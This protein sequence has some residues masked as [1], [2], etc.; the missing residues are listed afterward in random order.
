MDTHFY[1]F[2]ENTKWLVQQRTRAP[3]VRLSET[4]YLSILELKINDRKCSKMLINVFDF[5]CTIQLI[6]AIIGSSKIDR[7]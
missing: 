7:K 1:E 6:I 2:A 4:N 5:N 3:F